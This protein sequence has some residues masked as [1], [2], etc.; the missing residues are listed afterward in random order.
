MKENSK[1]SFLHNN[2]YKESIKQNNQNENNNNKFTKS[3]K[4]NYKYITICNDLSTVYDKRPRIAIRT[5][6]AKDTAL[7]DTGA[8]KS[9]V[10]LNFLRKH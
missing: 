4:P 8:N 1:K 2:Y 5:K 7:L 3:S 9:V 6:F 10:T